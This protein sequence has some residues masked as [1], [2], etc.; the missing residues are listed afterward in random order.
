M[1]NRMKSGANLVEEMN[2]SGCRPSP[3]P[4]GGSLALA[5][6]LIL[7]QSFSYHLSFLFVPMLF[8]FDTLHWGN[9]VWWSLL[10]ELKRI[11]ITMVLPSFI[12]TEAKRKGSI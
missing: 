5:A 2:G 1:Q 8:I 9:F 12:D 6:Q 10:L 11:V 7:I 4:A 3:T